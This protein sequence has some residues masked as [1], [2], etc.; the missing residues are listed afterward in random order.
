MS[1]PGGHD[2]SSNGTTAAED[3]GPSRTRTRVSRACTRCRQRKDRCDGATP[4]CANCLNADQQCSY[5]PITKKRGLPE[6]YVRAVE[7]LWAVTFARVTG[8]EDYML[9]MLH[10]DRDLLM[11]IWNHREVG[12]ELHSRWK[13][14][15]LFQELEAFLTGIDHSAAAGSKRKRD[16]EDE[17]EL[18]GSLDL[19]AILPPRY[20][21]KSF[22]GV[23]PG[24]EPLDTP[25]ARTIQLPPAAS[26]LL[27]HYFKFTHC[28][29]PILDRPQMLRRCYE[30][31]RTATE[32]TSS[33]GDLAVL[34]ATLA[35]TSRH[36]AKLR[37]NAVP[38]LLD[39][40]T[41]SK[42]ARECVPSTQGSFSLNHLQA[43]LVLALSDTAV[44][45]WESAWRSVGLAARSLLE[46]S[47]GLIHGPR[48]RL[49]THQGCLVLDTLISIQLDRPPQFRRYDHTA[50]S[51]LR[52]DG[53]EEW[54]TWPGTTAPA[55]V[56][57]CFNGLT[58][59]SALLNNYF[60]EQQALSSDIANVRADEAINQFNLLSLDYP[61]AS[62]L[63][64]SETGPPHQNWLKL[65]HLLAIAYVTSLE[66]EKV[67]SS[68]AALTSASK[69]LRELEKKAASETAFM[70][71]WIMGLMYPIFRQLKSLV[72]GA[73][74]VPPT[75]HISTL[76]AIAKQI[77]DVFWPVSED[78]TQ[79]LELIVRVQVAAPVSKEPQW[80]PGSLP[81][82]DIPAQPPRRQP[83]F[84]SDPFAQ[85]ET[86][87]MPRNIS[88]H[89][90]FMNGSGNLQSIGGPQDWSSSIDI[91]TGKTNLRDGG[92]TMPAGSG[93]FTVPSAGTYNPSI[94]TSPSFQGDEIDALFHEMAQLDT[95]EWTTGRNQGLRDFGF[96]DLTFEQFCN[97]PDRLF[98]AGFIDPQPENLGQRA[99]SDF[100]MPA[101][102]PQSHN[103]AFD[104]SRNSWNG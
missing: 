54:E 71:A 104:M 57:S 87:R 90:N 53:H 84:P 76:R 33:N 41:M 28:W 49:A 93:S 15:R 7:K 50:E 6:G 81:S 18:D 64:K 20:A 21:L 22:N 17:D 5:D 70:P 37:G 74:Y 86:S 16:K 34:A 85:A 14:S 36:A 10:Q 55:F 82:S 45:A 23:L 29:F 32:I 59:L 79:L 102:L 24:C 94:A 58:R 75:R 3:A 39:F 68:I 101:I 89:P 61:P 65:T 66:P 69:V 2:A 30:M 73:R 35:Y 46:H 52:P 44:G 47:D 19:N 77:S 48:D 51:C 27:S 96:D 56:I 9:L 31:T 40:A 26:E 72:D 99:D 43:L 12:E 83:F 11:N 62:Q 103:L 1:A 4:S 60:C 42:L 63:G 91:T 13:D 100:N 25:E 98:S 97:D 38:A 80:Q 8:L 67:E 95:T 78:L 88:Q 92:L